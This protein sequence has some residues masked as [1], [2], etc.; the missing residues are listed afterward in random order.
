[1]SGG[2]ASLEWEAPALVLSVAPFG[3][4]DALVH[5]FS[6]A[7]GVSH[8]LV[9]GGLGRRNAATWQNGNLVQAQWRTRIPGQL[10]TISGELAGPNA[11]RALSS[12]ASLACLSSLCAVADSA[13]A[14]GEPY[15]GLCQDSAQVLAML[16][17]QGVETEI[18]TLIRWETVLLR[19]LGFALDLS[20]CAVTGQ[21]DALIYVSPRTGRAVSREGAGEWASRLLPLPGFL[22]EDADCGAPEDWR[23]GLR[24]TGHFLSR[25][26]F[27]PLHRPLPAARIRLT[28]IVQSFVAGP[29][30]D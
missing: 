10:G 19:D 1:M 7:Q 22:I 27:G 29:V 9:K 2:G 8:G 18:S 25:D 15:P 6:P 14:E 3:E 16:G 23:D 21:A 17:T 30:S 13:L 12:R 4:A 28:D 5:L 24:L 26:V 20:C 11:A